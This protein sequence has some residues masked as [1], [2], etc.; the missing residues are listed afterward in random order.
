MNVVHF[1]TYLKSLD[2]KHYSSIK[3][4][5]LAE[6]R[7]KWRTDGATRCRYAYYTLLD[8]AIHRIP[9]NEQG[10]THDGD[11]I[12]GAL[13]RGSKQA[14]RAS[15][16]RRKRRE[17]GRKVNAR[18][19]KRKRGTDRRRDAGKMY[20]HARASVAERI[21]LLFNSDRVI[22]LAR[23][24]CAR[25]RICVRAK[26]TRGRWRKRRAKVFAGLGARLERESIV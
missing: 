23:L 10:R 15:E 18:R 8:A 24:S 13:Q 17:R 11:F 12:R 6:T 22:D 2:G 7:K 21:V 9:M 3:R 25:G 26:H 16:R 20:A 14:G 19:G 4:M 1:R 5:E